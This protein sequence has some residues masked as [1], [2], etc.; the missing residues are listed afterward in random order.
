MGFLEATLLVVSPSPAVAALTLAKV[1]PGG[2]IGEPNDVPGD[3]LVPA[4]LAPERL[5]VLFVPA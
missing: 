2:V 3:E 4:E 1:V 5:R